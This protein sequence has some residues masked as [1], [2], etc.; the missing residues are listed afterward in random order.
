[1]HKA[2]FIKRTELCKVCMQIASLKFISL[3]K[4]LIVAVSVLYRRRNGTFYCHKTFDSY[5][6]YIMVVNN[7]VKRIKM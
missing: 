2:D 4:L 1:M 7:I 3:I 5:L 6:S